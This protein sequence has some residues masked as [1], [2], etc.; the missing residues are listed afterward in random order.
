MFTEDIGQAFDTAYIRENFDHLP[1][2]PILNQITM[3]AKELGATRIEI[4]FDMIKTLVEELE[5]NL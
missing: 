3:S 2:H 5:A 1:N 4:M